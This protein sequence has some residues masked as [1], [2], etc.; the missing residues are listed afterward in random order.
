[1]KKAILVLMVMALMV[2]ISVGAVQAAPKS[3]VQPILTMDTGGHM[4]LIRKIVVT[5]DGRYLVSASDDKTIRVWDAA[6]GKET[7]KILGQIGGGGEGM[8]FAIAPFAR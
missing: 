8:I 4:A 3:D 7:R 1:M 6:T 5:K 2:A